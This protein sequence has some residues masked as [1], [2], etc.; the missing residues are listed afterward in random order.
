M[1]E[2]SLCFNGGL[3]QKRGSHDES[4]RM[5][6]EG[7][8]KALSCSFFSFFSFF[9][10]GEEI[11]QKIQYNLICEHNFEA[12]FEVIEEKPRHFVQPS[13]HSQP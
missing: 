13:L 8:G 10:E 3:K 4:L 1:C 12:A 6:S 9:V 11:K 2:L 5:F 7:G